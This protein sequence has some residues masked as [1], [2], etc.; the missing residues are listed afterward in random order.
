MSEFSAITLYDPL[1][2]FLGKPLDG[3]LTYTFDDAV[4]LCGHACPTVAGAYLMTLKG[5][6]SLYGKMIPERGKIRVYVKESPFDTNASV[7]TSI[8][9]LIT[10]A[11]N[12]GGF[13]GIGGEFVRKNLLTFHTDIIGDVKFERCDT[14]ES[15][16]LRYTP[17]II[18]VD[19]HQMRIMQELM[20]TPENS[21]LKQTFVTLWQKRVNE[22]LDRGH[23]VV[24]IV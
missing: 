7:M 1:A 3:L 24:S 19:V 4:K 12:E 14:K 22:I 20:R 17:S 10:G 15:V 5:L 21:D 16:R 2:S 8:Y 11:A 6:F 18:P 13:S 23:E 9:T